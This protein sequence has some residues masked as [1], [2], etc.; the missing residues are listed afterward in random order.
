MFP[1]FHALSVSK[2]V[3][4]LFLPFIIYPPTTPQSVLPVADQRV[5]VRGVCS[6]RWSCDGNRRTPLTEE[7]ERVLEQLGHSTKVMPLS[8]NRWRSMGTS[9]KKVHLGNVLVCTCSF[10]VSTVFVVFCCSLS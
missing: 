2:S 9:P 1:S 7:S 10:A 6:L 8:V 4:G 5:D 3:L